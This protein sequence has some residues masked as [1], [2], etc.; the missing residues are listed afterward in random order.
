MITIYSKVGCPKCKV[1]KMKL[2]QKG[3]E[4]DECQDQEKMAGLGF[5]SLPVLDVD[6]T[7]MKFE[8]AVKYVN[9][10]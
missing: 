6:G 9:Q 1:L 3:M 4:Y 5:K 10:L 7:V 2:D 8:D